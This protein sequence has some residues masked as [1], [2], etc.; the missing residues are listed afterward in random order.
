MLFLFG[1]NENHMRTMMRITLATAAFAVVHSA[2]ATRTA[3]RAAGKLVGDHQRD[4]GYRIVFVGQSLLGFAWLVTYAASL[5]RKTVYRITG[6]A[7]LLLRL[8]QAAGV[9]HLLAGLRAIGFTRWAGLRN[10]SAYCEGR[11]IPVGPIAQGPEI[12]DNGQLAAS[13]PFQS[14]RH[15]L[16]FAGI[17]LFWLTPHMTTRRLGF[18]IVSTVYFVLGSAHEEARLADAYGDA[19][20]AYRSKGMPFFW[21]SLPFVKAPAD[22]VLPRQSR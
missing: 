15:P 21:P 19:Y 7:A 1:V 13:G 22:A 2:L 8:G 9:L 3:K 16:N 17:P 14:S 5:P 4:A 6:P 10:F 20:R 18:N 12:M 11:P